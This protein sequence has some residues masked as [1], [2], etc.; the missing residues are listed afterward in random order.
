VSLSAFYFGY[1][2]EAVSVCPPTVQ[3]LFSQKERYN[4]E[5][6]GRTFYSKVP[7]FKSQSRHQLTWSTFYVLLL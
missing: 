4:G 2:N 3:V 5:G 6:S 1:F 7:G